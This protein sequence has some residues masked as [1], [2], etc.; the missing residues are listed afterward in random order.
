MKG[1]CKDCEFFQK[2]P[3][4]E[5]KGCCHRY[6]PTVVSSTKAVGG[7]PWLPSKLP[8][9]SADSFCGEHRPKET[10]PETV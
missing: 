5:G 3:G 2:F 10:A 4:G 6:P 9:T 7:A 1:T 8:E